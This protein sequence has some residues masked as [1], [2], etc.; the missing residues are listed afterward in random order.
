MKLLS[1]SNFW[2]LILWQEVVAACMKCMYCL[3]NFVAYERWCNTAWLTRYI[4]L[5]VFNVTNNQVLTSDVTC[6]FC[7]CMQECKLPM[8]FLG[9]IHCSHGWTV[10]FFSRPCSHYPMQLGPQIKNSVP[11]SVIAPC[12]SA[13]TLSVGPTASEH[14]VWFVDGKV[15]PCSLTVPIGSAKDIAGLAQH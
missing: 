4:E 13:V 1:T 14:D 7:C 12:L 10:A 15:K 6:T 5:M 8:M 2:L 3:K 11:L 9:C